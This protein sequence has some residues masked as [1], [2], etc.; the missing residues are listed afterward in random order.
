MAILSTH[1]ADVISRAKTY[2][3]YYEPEI[4]K[5]KAAKST[6]ES[7]SQMYSEKINSLLGG[8]SLRPKESIE[9]DINAGTEEI[10]SGRMDA[11]RDIESRAAAM[12]F[13]SSGALDAAKTKLNTEASGMKAN[14]ARDVRNQAA[15]DSQ[16]AQLAALG[17]A[18]ADKTESGSENG[19]EAMLNKISS[20]GG[21]VQAAPRTTGAGPQ[22]VGDGAGAMAVAEANKQRAENQLRQGGGQNKTATQ[23]DDDIKK[24][25][26]IDQ[27]KR[28]TVKR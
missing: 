8:G 5:Q 13:G 17:F 25:Q 27:A 12:G 9:A 22:V 18:R 21:G 19:L 15:K 3:G 6:E 2:M 14:L 23:Y 1:P 24:G 16:Q 11:Q 28:G 10:E 26:A 20:K 7:N 4:K